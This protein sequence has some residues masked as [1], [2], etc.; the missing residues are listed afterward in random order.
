M[1]I[2]LD[3][4]LYL[5]DNGRKFKKLS[6][7][8]RAVLFTLAFRVGSNATTWISQR[9]LAS[10]LCI[11]DRNLR[12]HMYN[13]SKLGLI[14]I[15]KSK[16]DKRKLEYSIASFLINYHQ[17]TRIVDEKYRMKSSDTLENSGRN[18]PVFLSDTGRNH[19]VINST[20]D[21]QD[22]DFTKEN[23]CTNL[24]KATYINKAT[25]KDKTKVEKKTRTS[26][27]NI[28]LSPPEF[29]SKELWEEFLDHRK[30]IR[31]PMSEMA[32]KKAF[33][34][35]EKLKE[36]GQ[37]VEKVVNNSII[38]G[39]KGLFPIKE[40]TYGKVNSNTRNGGTEEFDIDAWLLKESDGRDIF[41][42]KIAVR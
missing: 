40:I 16:K 35:L 37:D 20:N 39:W 36:E 14:V 21:I 38:N 6:L 3:I 19:P 24:S 30:S 23:D 9:S 5:R 32:Q 22:N 41:G 33:K 8:D 4:A 34:V 15:K 11:E 28:C 25:I 13:L 2:S 7:S 12:N 10:E 31:S 17:A 27:S 29:L 26:C 18:H 42:N 1:S